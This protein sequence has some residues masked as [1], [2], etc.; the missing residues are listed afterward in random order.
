MNG[1]PGY[2]IRIVADVVVVDEESSHYALSEKQAK[3]RRHNACLF[4]MVSAAEEVAEFCQ[5]SCP[6]IQIRKNFNYHLS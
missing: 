1:S 5:D 2:M 4:T 3:R 6:E